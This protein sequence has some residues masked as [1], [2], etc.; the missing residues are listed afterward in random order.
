MT[1]RDAR[2]R[3]RASVIELLPAEADGAVAAAVDDALA[4]RM[5]QTAATDALNRRLSEMG[6]GPVSLSAF[7]R[8]VVRFSE[9]GI[10]PRY[11]KRQ[12]AFDAGRDFDI[13]IGFARRTLWLGF[14]A[15]FAAGALVTGALTFVLMLAGGA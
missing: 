14:L 4:G 7:N 13:Q 12:M 9:D 10:P 6:L 1:G 5:T 2:R 15:G 8:L 11:R 3:R